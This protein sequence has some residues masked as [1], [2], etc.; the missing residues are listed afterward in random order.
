MAARGASVAWI[1]AWFTAAAAAVAVTRM[2]DLRLS[3]RDSNRVIEPF[4][5]DDSGR[6]LLHRAQLAIGAI[7]RS[8]V[9]T[10][11]RG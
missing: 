1:I 8:E 4:S 6:Q 10:A 2:T 3:H 9:C 7:L 11:D 5:L